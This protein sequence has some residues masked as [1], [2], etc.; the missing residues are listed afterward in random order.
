LLVLAL[1]PASAGANE[2]T[3]EPTKIA[4]PDY[5]KSF[6]PGDITGIATAD[7][8]HYHVVVFSRSV[9]GHPVSRGLLIDDRKPSLVWQSDEL[10]GGNPK[11]TKF[12]ESYNGVP[13]FGLWLAE[14]GDPQFA[15]GNA[16]P[17]FNFVIGDG[18]VCS[19]GQEQCWPGN[20]PL[21]EI[22][23][24][25]GSPTTPFVPKYTRETTRVETG[26]YTIIAWTS[27]HTPTGRFTSGIVVVDTRLPSRQLWQSEESA[28][29]EMNITQDASWKYKGRPVFLVTRTSR[30]R[31]QIDVLAIVDGQVVRLQSYGRSARDGRDSLDVRWNAKRHHFVIL[32]THTFWCEDGS[33][34][35]RVT[36]QPLVVDTHNRRQF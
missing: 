35:C 12:Q 16:G 6:V 14:S 18:L 30:S 19:T 33:T 1:A 3:Q 23:E 11:I 9:N 36:F 31:L 28:T 25:G 34:T 5:A 29:D 8:E 17:F 24:L 27:D 22:S 26:P 13:I 20:I 32:P 21:S 7:Q 10:K 2:T 15:A 4:V